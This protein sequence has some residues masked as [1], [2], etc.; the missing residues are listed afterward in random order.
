MQA[1]D[2]AQLLESHVTASSL[3]NGF[4]ALHL[5]N[6][7][8]AANERFQDAVEILKSKGY[9]V[10]ESNF[11]SESRLGFGEYV[12]FE[13]SLQIDEILSSAS[14]EYFLLMLKNT[15]ASSETGETLKWDR[16]NKQLDK[17]FWSAIYK[18][19]SIGVGINQKLSDFANDY[20][21]FE[22][23]WPN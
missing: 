5:T 18:L 6:E 21:Y 11:I 15:I 16:P 12:G 23:T 3:V 14:R 4:K 8:V 17:D 22:F 1:R 7:A 13:I 10:R 9:K 19:S 20:T 2:L